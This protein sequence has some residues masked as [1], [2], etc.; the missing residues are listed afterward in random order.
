MDRISRERR[1][2]NMSRVRGR[3]TGPEIVVRRILRGLGVGFRLHVRGLPGQP[4]IVMKGRRRII[5]VRGCFWHRHPECRF[6]YQP[7]TR[8]EFWEAKFAANVER[9]RR[10]EQALIDS[11]WQVLTIWECETIDAKLLRER[12]VRFLGLE[13]GGVGQY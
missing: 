8:P 10:N 11:G 4:D 2:W 3:N 9:D 1:S 7:K 6:A 12:L 5:E 13:C